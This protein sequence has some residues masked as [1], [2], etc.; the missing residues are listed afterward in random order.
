MSDLY[1]CL[2]QNNYFEDILE[3]IT[4]IFSNVRKI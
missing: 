1:K 3:T 4:K 2:V